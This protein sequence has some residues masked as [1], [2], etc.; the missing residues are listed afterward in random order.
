MSERKKIYII[1]RNLQR[2]I[3]QSRLDNEKMNQTSNVPPDTF[4]IWGLVTQNEVKP[5]HCNRPLLI[6][7]ILK[8]FLVVYPL[9]IIGF[10]LC[11]YYPDTSSYLVFYYLKH[12]VPFSFMGRRDACREITLFPGRVICFR[13]DAWKEK[14]SQR[15]EKEKKSK[16]FHKRI[17]V[18]K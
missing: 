8:Q 9:V 10:Y 14:K 4:D 7:T 18:K 15:K 5:L 12:A 2:I 3:F 16:H 13:T 11:F 17:S 6:T 1:H